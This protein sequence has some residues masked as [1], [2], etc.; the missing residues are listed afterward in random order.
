MHVKRADMMDEKL[1][2]AIDLGTNTTLLLVARLGGP[3]QGST[4]GAAIEVV[5]DECRTPRLGAGVAARKTLDPAARE[6]TIQVLA[7]FARKLDA[8]GVARERT[9]VVGTA[10]LRRATDAP[11]FV[12]AV[13]AR[14]GLEVE[15]LPAEEEARLGALAAAGE[16]VGDDAVVVDVGG[17]SSEIA[18]A[19]LDLRQSVPIGAVV[20][21]EMFPAAADFTA[22]Q[23]HA[24]AQA[25]AFPA[26]VARERTVVALGGTAVN[27]ACLVLD[28]A[29]FDARAAEGATVET[30]RVRE[31]GEELA[32]MPVAARLALP[33][34]AERALILPAG[35]A[36]LAATLER[37][38]A[39]RVRV[40]GRGLRYG[41]VREILARNR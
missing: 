5:H 36:C 33:L 30:T 11:E 39:A 1:A 35:L 37:I 9:R 24:R 15:I 2:A 16:G 6:R 25:A 34:E 27:A 21:S 19:A 18:C 22:L 8:L 7:H 10:V 23:E 17:G 20:L 3:A 41:V 14:V 32:R 31:L 12:A 38:G 4:S 29:R 28:L 40:S 13:R 26:D